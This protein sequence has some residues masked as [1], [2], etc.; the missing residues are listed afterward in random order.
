MPR[1]AGSQSYNGRNDER[2]F[3]IV[4]MTGALILG[5]GFCFI[6]VAMNSREKNTA[7]SPAS[8]TQSSDSRLIQPDHPRRLV[9]FTLID[10]TG[11]VIRRPDVGGE[12]LI[13]NFL[14]TSC[15]LTCPAV[16]RTMA[17]IQ[18]LTTNQMDVKLISLTVDPRDD[19]PDVL[20]EYGKRFGADTDRWLFLTG[21]RAQLY[22][23]IGTSFLSPDTSSAFGFMPGNF[24]HTERIA[25]VDS[26]GSLRGFFDGLNQNTA[27][28][29]INEITRLRNQHL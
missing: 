19:T 15:T 28:A 2:L 26:D 23:L 9:N 7:N 20:A 10:H 13:V 3:V 24:A 17:Q 8:I 4:G 29:V 22:E 5:A 25:I 11:H 14:L 12:I 6:L 16:T 18:Q 27:T 21:D 1:N